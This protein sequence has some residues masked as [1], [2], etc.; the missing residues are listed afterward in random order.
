MAASGLRWLGGVPLCPGDMGTRRWGTWWQSVRSGGQSKTLLAP[1]SPLPVPPAGRSR[2]RWCPWLPWTPRA[3]RASRSYRTSGSQ[4]SDGKNRP[5]RLL[6]R[7]LR[8]AAPA[9]PLITDST[10]QSTDSAP[11]LQIPLLAP[12]LITDSAPQPNGS[13]SSCQ[14]LHPTTSNSFPVLQTPPS[15]PL[16]PPPCQR[17]C[18]TAH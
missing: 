18:S 4:R 17:I 13:T 10:Q 14:R 2:D 11:L 8:P 9:P 16:A 12:P 7:R 6:D 1:N 15:S 3:S 5:A